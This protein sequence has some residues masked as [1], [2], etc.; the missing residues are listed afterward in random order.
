MAR[1]R[2][3]YKNKA[4]IVIETCLNGLKFEEE[5]YTD[6][7]QL[8]LSVFDFSRKRIVEGIERLTYKPFSFSIDNPNGYSVVFKG[9][10]QKIDYDKED[11]E[12]EMF[13]SLNDDY[14][15][16]KCPAGSNKCS[17]EYT[18]LFFWPSTMYS[19]S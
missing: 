10:I 5:N 7:K 2:T 19:P 9:S 8:P 4:H 3:F 13:C 14:I 15:R 1:K 16:L 11:L 12:M 18:G 17:L 6:L